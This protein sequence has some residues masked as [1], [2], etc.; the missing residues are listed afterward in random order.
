MRSL[1]RKTPEAL[2]CDD[3]RALQLIPDLEAV[4]A[5]LRPRERGARARRQDSRGKRG[6]AEDSATHDRVRVCTRQIFDRIS[7]GASPA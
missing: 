5:M 3:L 6:I 4:G 7:D 2:I 1:T